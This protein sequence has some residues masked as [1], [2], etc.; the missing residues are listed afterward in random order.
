M[1]QLASSAQLIVQVCNIPNLEKYMNN[2]S[3]L[4]KRPIAATALGGLI[5]GSVTGATIAL[6]RST[7]K[8]KAKK[9][10]PKQAGAEILREAGI[11]GLATAI[12]GASTATLGLRGVFSIAGLALFTAGAKYAIESIVENPLKD[13]KSKFTALEQ[14]EK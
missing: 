4:P 8:V 6:V 10:T 2:I 12:G 14:A 9:I 5:A 11:M 3:T 7:K 1:N 13:E